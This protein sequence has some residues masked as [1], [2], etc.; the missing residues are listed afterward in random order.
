M[1]RK[2][3]LDEVVNNLLSILPFFLKRFMKPDHHD[4]EHE[5]GGSHIN[6]LFML[7]KLGDMPMSEVSRRIFVSKPQMT[8]IID[9]LIDMGLVDRLP[10]RRDR[11]VINIAL[12]EKG[13][14]YLKNFKAAK[15]DKIK[16]RLANLS[17]DDLSV[18]A[19]SLANIKNV[20]GKLSSLKDLG[21]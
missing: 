13:H 10:D 11:R 7:N 12:T 18:L 15:R 4:S 17:D 19:E 16:E 8:V 20:L 9:K 3:N 14:A 21:N 6:V 2:L 5:L 1:D